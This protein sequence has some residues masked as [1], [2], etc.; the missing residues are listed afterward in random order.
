ME[1][2]V[3]PEIPEK[4]TN[5]LRFILL[6][7]IISALLLS[8]I[9]WCITYFKKPPAEF[10]VG[11]PIEV[12]RGMNM[13]GI[14]HLLQVRN[15]VRSSLFLNFVLLT[16]Y[17]PADIKASTY[18]FSE[19]LDVFGVAKRLSEGDFSSNLVRF[20]H[21]E[22]ERAL[23][24]AE[25]AKKQLVNFDQNSF[26]KEAIPLEGKLFPDTYFIPTNYTAHELITTMLDNYEKNINPLRD[27]IIKSGLTEQE[28]ITLA[29][30]VEREA[31]SSESMGLVSGILRNRLEL[32]MALQV[33]ASIE[34]VLDK[35]L[36]EL[37]PSD[38]ELD[39]L[40]N[41]YNHPGLPPSPIGNP[42][43]ESIQAVLNPTNS[44]YL[45]YLTDSEG[46]FH[47]ANSFEEHKENIALYLR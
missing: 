15:V 12:T 16:K 42:G 27:D 5:Q 32:G 10:P 17:N 41:T 11:E 30:I 47:Y 20:T 25:T 36:Q 44:K 1:Q 46:I 38:L 4:K 22:G 45:Y 31:N 14:S 24:I 43:L 8:I 39:S 19:P 35:S 21:R 9:I 18:V 26:L 7:I 2:T 28:I 34:Y 23:Y 13:E 40:Y 3:T 6:S 33:D 29:S 37:S